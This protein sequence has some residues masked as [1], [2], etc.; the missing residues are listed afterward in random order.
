MVAKRESKHINTHKRINS[1]QTGKFH[2]F[3]SEHLII[4]QLHENTSPTMLF[5]QSNMPSTNIFPEQE[6]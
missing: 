6:K 5:A 3:I 4:E 2:P 1:A